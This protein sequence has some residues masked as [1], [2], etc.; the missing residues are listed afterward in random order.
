MARSLSRRRILGCHEGLIPS[1]RHLSG[2]SF[3]ISPRMAKYGKKAQSKVKRAMHERKRGTLRS[4]R[5]GKK[6]TSR[7]Q[8][9][10]IGLSEARS[11][12]AKVPRKR[13]GGKKR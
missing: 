10:A 6:V 4:G 8:A 7:K 11:A 13:K 2:T 3:A 1:G 5:S 12:G 9:I